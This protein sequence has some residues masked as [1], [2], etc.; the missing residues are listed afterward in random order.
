MLCVSVIAP[1]P[2]HSH[3]L[4][5]IEM[6]VVDPPIWVW[7]LKCFVCPL[8]PPPNLSAPTPPPS[9]IHTFAFTVAVLCA[10]REEPCVVW[11]L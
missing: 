1:G 8:V 7:R 11:R 6:L 4:W 9:N 10:K 2:G 5:V 3:L